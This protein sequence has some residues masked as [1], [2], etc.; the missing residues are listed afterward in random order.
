LI[1]INILQGINMMTMNGMF[2]ISWTA[3]VERINRCG[4]TSDKPVSK[5]L[6]HMSPTSYET[7]WHLFDNVHPELQSI[8][9]E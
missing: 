1:C 7:L 8:C 2:Y 6:C 3:S 4:H 5:N 9:L